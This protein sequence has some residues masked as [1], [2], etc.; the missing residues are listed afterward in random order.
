MAT[1]YY[2]IVLRPVHPRD[3]KN[4]FKMST[5]KMAEMSGIPKRSL[6]FYLSGDREPKQFIL[7]LF[8]LL[9][10]ELEEN[11]NNHVDNDDFL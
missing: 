8:G 5:Y 3:F 6:D 10:K 2:N 4:R 11:H 9:A 7:N 1:N